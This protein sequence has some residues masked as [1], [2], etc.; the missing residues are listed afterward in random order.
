[1]L[2]WS[3]MVA[4]LGRLWPR[5]TQCKLFYLYDCT[6]T[7]RRKEREKE[8]EERERTKETGF[9]TRARQRR[10]LHAAKLKRSAVF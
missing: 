3:E 4:D 2:L 5:D 10:V 1:M 9:A 8:R 7:E 6:V